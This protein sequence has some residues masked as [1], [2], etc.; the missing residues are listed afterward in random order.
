MEHYLLLAFI[1][2]VSEP[3]ERDFSDCLPSPAMGL[4]W[5]RFLFPNISVIVSLTHH[6]LKKKNLQTFADC[7]KKNLIAGP[8]NIIP[9]FDKPI[10]SMLSG[11]FYIYAHR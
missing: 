5:C 2:Y 11:L 10:S 9:L 6:Q 8:I 7:C 3:N 4:P 1:K